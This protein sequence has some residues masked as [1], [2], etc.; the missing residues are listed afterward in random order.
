MMS[1]TTTSH[2]A[3]VH[4]PSPREKDELTTRKSTQI[5]Q[6][7]TRCFTEFPLPPATL[8]TIAEPVCCVQPVTFSAELG[9][10]CA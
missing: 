1:V 6:I 5:H 10:F 7:L 3:T 8:S 2:E 9:A 4:L